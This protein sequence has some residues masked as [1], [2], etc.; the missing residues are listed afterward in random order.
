MHYAMQVKD[1]VLYHLPA[2]FSL[3]TAT[4]PTASVPWPGVASFVMKSTTNGSDLTVMTSLS[5]GFTFLSPDEYGQ[6]RDFY[7][8]VAAAD[9]QQLVLHATEA[10]KGN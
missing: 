9:Q 6:L 2:G 1:G 7:Q 8:K 4:G 3:E 5:R 10:P